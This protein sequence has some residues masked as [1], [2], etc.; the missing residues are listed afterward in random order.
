[1]K[2]KKHILTIIA[3]LALSLP[4]FA[5]FDLYGTSTVIQL[6]PCQTITANT[7]NAGVAINAYIGTAVCILSYTNTA[8]TNST[9]TCN[10]EDSDDN[11][12][13][14]AVSDSAFTLVTNTTALYGGTLTVGVT[15]GATKK[16]VRVVQNITGTSSPSFGTSVVFVGRKKYN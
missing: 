1:M 2:L 11:T 6:A 3:L 14:T 4:A 16:Y 8:G 7:T 12:N 9:L 10:V 13:F 5:Q 15:P